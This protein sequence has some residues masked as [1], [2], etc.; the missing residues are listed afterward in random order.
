LAHALRAHAGTG[1][2]IEWNALRAEAERGTPVF[3][4][5]H[6]QN[7]GVRASGG[8]ER[9]RYYVGADLD[10]EGGIE[11]T[12][13]LRR[14]S[15]RS[16][17]DVKFGDKA[18]L[19]VNLGLVSSDLNLPGEIFSGPWYSMDFGHPL[20]LGTPRRGFHLAPPEAWREA[21]ENKSETNRFTAGLQLAHRPKPW[22]SHRLALGIDLVNDD[23]YTLFRNIASDTYLRQFTPPFGSPLGTK[24]ARRERGITNTLD[25]GITATASITRALTSSTSAGLQVYR[26]YL[27]FQTAEGRDFPD[28]SVESISAAATTF[29]SD[30]FVENVT[31][32]TYVQQQ[33]GWRNRLFLTGAL[34]ADDNSAFGENFN[35][36]YYPKASLSWVLSEE[37]FWRVSF[38]DVLKLRAAYGQSGQQP[39]AFAAIRT[40]IPVPG[41][42]G[43][44]GLISGASG[45]A[46]L[47]PERSKE[48]EMGLEAGLLRGRLGLD[49]TFYSKTTEDAI[50]AIPNV[51]SEGFG[52]DPIVQRTGTRFENLGTVRNRGIEALVRGRVLEGRSVGWELDLKLSRNWNEVVQLVGGQDQ[53]VALGGLIRHSEGH[54]AFSVFT[55]R[56][57]SA[58]VGTDGIARNIMCDGGP[59]NNNQPVACAPSA[60]LFAGQGLPKV[61]GSGSTTLTLFGK[62]RF[63]ALVDFKTGHKLFDNSAYIRCFFGTCRERVLPAEFDPLHIGAIQGTQ[64]DWAVADAGFAKLREVSATYSVPAA[65]ARAVGVSRATV[66]VAGRNLHTWTSWPDV[67]PEAYQEWAGVAN[68]FAP[69]NTT[70]QLAQFVATLNLTF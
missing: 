29:S 41:P 38:V 13:S 44:P 34:R 48:I 2:L 62:L 21:M 6:L 7:Y 51:P 36:V 19:S 55:R 46:D 8:T 4:T 25:Y 32:G 28:F 68:L 37:P 18:D 42:T 56:V 43:A 70:P 9:F 35:L 49:L 60:R 5:G 52:V 61:E 45:N 53:I 59:T 10:D 31:V 65:W 69:R 30:G 1:A 16:N 64:F 12:N 23:S 33:I 24:W 26:N 3:R 50:L 67:D 66:S 20:E 40:Y 54:P 17:L 27:S 11:T 58:D 39:Q 14:L 63:Y 22:L 47:G 15:G 57:V